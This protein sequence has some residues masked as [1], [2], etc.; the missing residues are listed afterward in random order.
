MTNKTLMLILSLE[1]ISPWK[2]Y[3]LKKLKANLLVLEK[4]IVELF[5][6]CCDGDCF[7]LIYNS[8]WIDEQLLKYVVTHLVIVQIW[9][10]QWMSWCS[11][12]FLTILNG[13]KS[14]ACIQVSWSREQQIF[15]VNGKEILLAMWTLSQYYSAIVSTKTVRDQAHVHGWVPIKL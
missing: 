13:F 14:V 3:S 7:P 9:L 12:L 10:N 8:P 15:P 5:S 4:Y 11:W 6:Y 2:N 1:K